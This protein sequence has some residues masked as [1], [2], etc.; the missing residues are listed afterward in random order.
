MKERERNLHLF[1]FLSVLKGP[2]AGH[3]GQSRSLLCGHHPLQLPSNHLSIFQLLLATIPHQLGTTSWWPQA[4]PRRGRSWES[5]GKRHPGAHP[6]PGCLSQA[7]RAVPGL[8]WESSRARRTWAFWAL[9]V[10]EAMATEDE[11]DLSA[12]FL[13]Q[14]RQNLLPLLR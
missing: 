3:S 1:R 7:C 6:L 11:E 9:L 10:A 5:R 8:T 12:Y 14:Y 2:G 4:G 13:K